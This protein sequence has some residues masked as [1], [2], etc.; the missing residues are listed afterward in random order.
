MAFIWSKKKLELSTTEPRA[1]IGWTQILTAERTG[2]F[3]GSLRV[4]H[5]S[6]FQGTRQPIKV[7]FAKVFELWGVARGDTE[8]VA[9]LI[10]ESGKNYVK[11]RKVSSQPVIVALRQFCS[12][13]FMLE[14]TKLVSKSFV[15]LR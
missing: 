9:T 10:W 2:H 8:A 7:F 5:E 4:Y 15:T 12:V 3:S 6:D 11:T 1:W 13:H 14:L